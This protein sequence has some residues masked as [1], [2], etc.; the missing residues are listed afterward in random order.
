MKRFGDKPLLSRQPW[1]VAVRVLVL[2]SL[3]LQPVSLFAKPVTGPAAEDLTIGAPLLRAPTNGARTTGVNYPP[4]GVPKLEWDP[5]VGAKKYEVEISASAGFATPLVKTNTFGTTYTHL[6][7]LADGEYFWRVRADDGKNWGPH[8]EVRSFTKDWSADGNLVVQLISP[9]EDAERAAFTND[10]F[11]WQP[12]PG[13]AYYRFEISTDPSFSN[14]VYAAQSIK[15]Q[16][17]PIKRLANNRYYWRVTPVDKQDHFGVPSTARSFYF[18]WA[19]APRLLSPAPDIDSAFVP[20]FSWTAVEAAIKYQLQISTQPDFASTSFF[21]TTNTAYTPDKALGNDQD[22]YWRVKA[23]DAEKSSSP[24]SE[25]RRFRAKWNF[26]AKLLAPVQN[27]IRQSSPF[28]SWTPIPGAERYQVRVD[29]SSAF[30]RPLIDQRFFNVP[31]AALNRLSNTTV[32][33]DRDYFWQ[34]RGIDVQGNFTPW[35]D[36]HT[37]QFG[38]QE[39]SP[40]LIYPL[41]YYPPDTVNLPVHNDRTIAWPLF[42]WDSSIIYNPLLVGAFTPAYYELTVAATPDFQSPQFQIVSTGQAAAPTLEKPFLNLQDG[43][44]Y[45][46]RVRAFGNSG[47]Q[48]GVDHI[49]QTRID[50]RTPQLPMSTSITPIYPRDAFE[51]VISAPLLG[52]LPVEGAANYRVQIATDP[53]FNT[54]VDEAAPQFVNYAPWQG[55]LTPMPFGTYWWRVRAESAPNN[56]LGGW[57]EVRRFNLSVDLMVGNPNDFVPPPYPRS[58]LGVKPDAPWYDA[59]MTQI[60]GSTVTSL[61]IAVDY[62]IDDLHIMLNR[63]DLKSAEFPVLAG[64]L[65]WL[66]AFRTADSPSAAVKYGIY[67]DADHL[68]NSGGASDPLGKA[69]TVNNLYLPDYVIYVT[70]ADNSEIIP[71]NVMLYTWNSTSQSWGAGRSLASIGGDSWYATDGTNAIQLQIPHGALGADATDFVGSLAFTVFSTSADNSLGMVD[72]IPPQDA[73]INRPAFVSNMLMP[74]YPFD[75]PLSNPSIH[76]DMP[77]LR[78]RM[79]YY[80]SNDGYLVQV[81]SDA[82]FTTIIET[83]EFSEQSISPLYSFLPTTFQSLNAYND[84]ESYYWRVRPRYERHKSSNSEFDYGPWS[85]SMRFKLESRLVGNPRLSTGAVA[86]TTPTFLWER[87]EG[88]S[89]Y[90]L[91]IDSDANFSKPDTYELA[92]TS[93]TPIVPLRDGTFY[94]RVAIKRANN[95]IGRWTPTMSFVMQSVTPIP[96]A[97]VNS[98]IING[99]PTFK[100][101]AVLTPTAE[102]RIAAPIY[103]LQIDKDPNF[104]DPTTYKTQST[105]FTI[106]NNKSLADGLWHWRVAILYADTEGGNIRAYS[107][108]QRFYKEYLAPTLLQP[109][110]NSVISGIT[111]FEWSAVP[112][113]AYYQIEIADNE[114][115]NNSIK[116]T[117]DNTRYT[118]TANLAP[119]QYHWRVRI[120]DYNKQPGPFVTG[121]IQVQTVSLSV[122]NYVWIDENNDGRV[123]SGEL[124]VP[125]GVV[126]ELLSGAGSP[127]NKTTQTVNGYYRFTGLDIGEYRVR[128]AAGNFIPGGLL[129]KYG[130]STGANQE[131]DPNLDGDQNDNGMDSTEPSVDGIVSGKFSLTQNEPLGELPTTS[132]NPGDDGAGTADLDSNLTVDF[133]VSPSSKLYSIGNFVGLD[134]NN[135]GQIDLDSTQKPMPVPDGVLLELLSGDSAALLTAATVEGGDGSD[136]VTILRTTTTKSGF[137]LFSGLPAGNYRLRIA[138]SNFMGNGVLAT[139]GPSTGADQETDPNNNGDQNDNGLDEGTPSVN[140]IISGVITLGGTGPTNESTT[141]IGQPGDDGRGTLD[142]NSNLTIDFALIP[143]KPTAA[144]QTVYLPVIRR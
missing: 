17:T 76:N 13:A 7:A 103:Q 107:P 57:S 75:T 10:D 61:T 97:P 122:G 143:G 3:L 23:I 5:V 16:H 21:E 77:P 117:T 78:W 101:T 134:A 96:L 48:F 28:F 93:Y 38:S 127:L 89:G 87:V 43:T 119:K 124:P 138:A 60:A 111:S 2:L 95:V 20:S 142:A 14:I 51:S 133:G 100:W 64:N 46:W 131:G 55:R 69:I 120:Y 8:S 33:L 104:G 128:L 81:A 24:W 53:N 68:P 62:D 121:R 27:T 12:I 118:P 123:D 25:V 50:R 22:Y 109:G 11:I 54:I 139:Y 80:D 19:N 52:W 37:F 66:I 132:G 59:T 73:T 135:D 63:I 129:Q 114:Q 141:A 30:S 65:N 74:L 67:V 130:H 29:S 86:N 137:Y 88:A 144:G 92:G 34:V 39:I 115:F 42:V 26:Q 136:G 1:S 83:W 58:L 85:P 126:V 15:A 102:P 72:T 106:A 18:G 71:A 9:P 125:D 79:P 44:L 4:L 112:E 110:Q 35:S 47:I 41:P 31:T 32:H 49:W 91:Q 98:M 84:N 36:L 140:G 56:A 6:E 105:A 90:R 94:W 116:A 99:Q 45:Y 40:N 82:K 70:P 113:A 108:V